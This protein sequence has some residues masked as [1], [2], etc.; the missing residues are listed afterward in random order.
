MIASVRF[1]YLTD[2]ICPGRARLG[3]GRLAALCSGRLDSLWFASDDVLYVCASALPAD[4]API[5]PV[6]TPLA[7][8]ARGGIRSFLELSHPR[9]PSR[10]VASLELSHAVPPRLALGYA[11]EITSAVPT[12][13]IWDPSASPPGGAH[14]EEQIL[15]PCRLAL[16]APPD[17]K[18]PTESPSHTRQFPYDDEVFRIIFSFLSVHDLMSFSET[19][20]DAREFCAIV[21]AEPH[22]ADFL[23]KLSVTNNAI[24]ANTRHSDVNDRAVVS[25]CKVLVLARYLSVVNFEHFE[26]F[27]L[28]HPG[29]ARAFTAN[30]RLLELTL[31]DVGPLTL[32]MVARMSSPDLWNLDLSAKSDEGQAA[33]PF[34]EFQQSLVAFPRLTH[35]TLRN[36]AF[37]CDAQTPVIPCTT[38]HTLRLRGC[39]VPVRLAMHAFPNVRRLELR[40]GPNARWGK[41]ER[42]ICS[43]IEYDVWSLATPVHR[44]DLADDLMGLSCCFERAKRCAARVLSF[45]VK[46]DHDLMRPFRACVDVPTTLRF[47]EFTLVPHDLP[48]F[49][50]PKVRRREDGGWIYDMTGGQKLWVHTITEVA[51]FCAKLGLRGIFL[52]L[53]LRLFC[54]YDE[55]VTRETVSA[56]VQTLARACPIEFVGVAV[57]TAFGSFESRPIQPCEREVARWWRVVGEKP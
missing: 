26:M 2:V 12:F 30:T 32:G 29:V 11:N 44:L 27:L 50:T 18:D 57:N 55:D 5:R 39:A 16:S 25:L 22:R 43:L 48:N 19:C 54:E 4:L 15:S 31:W 23:Q 21:L 51:L 24:T 28:C 47:V 46:C 20:K 42:L 34:S 33:F 45:H 38:V 7:R 53:R 10:P 1:W 40:R 41:L 8:R 9:E 14:Y 37:D 56:F 49:K 13:P 52:C 3:L 35:L 36:I 6:T 17:I